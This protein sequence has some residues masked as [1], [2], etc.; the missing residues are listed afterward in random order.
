MQ[1]S[2]GPRGSPA[3]HSTEP[4]LVVK[5]ER[6]VVEDPHLGANGPSW[7][8][9][10]TVLVPS[11]ELRMSC[12]ERSAKQPTTAMNDKVTPAEKF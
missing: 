4:Q 8:R 9:R 1:T 10:L 6:R 11:G 3:R 2:S 12:I 7:C 5:A